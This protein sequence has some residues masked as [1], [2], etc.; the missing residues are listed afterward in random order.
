MATNTTKPMFKD[1]QRVMVKF[2]NGEEVP[3]RAMAQTNENFVS[4]NFG[5]FRKDGRLWKW[6]VDSRYTIQT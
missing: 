1:G 3:T 4:T 2:P 6:V 5:T